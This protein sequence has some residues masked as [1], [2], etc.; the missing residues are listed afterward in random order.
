M[1][2]VQDFCPNWASAP[3]ETIADLLEEQG[4]KQ[5]SFAERMGYTDKH[6]SLLINGKA[7]I[8]EDAAFKL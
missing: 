5:S 2:S 6:I 1:P 4:W 7:A 3:G 8:T